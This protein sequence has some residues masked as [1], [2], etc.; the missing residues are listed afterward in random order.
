[1]MLGEMMIKPNVVTRSQLATGINLSTTM[2]FQGLSLEVRPQENQ[3]K[4]EKVQIKKS[5]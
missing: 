5:G 4:I 1:M 2:A 3:R